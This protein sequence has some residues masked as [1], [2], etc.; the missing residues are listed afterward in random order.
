MSWNGRQCHCLRQL[1]KLKS[2]KMRSM[3]NGDWNEELYSPHLCAL[4]DSYHPTLST[5]SLCE[6]Q[7]I[8]S[9]PHRGRIG[10]NINL[11]FFPSTQ[12][13]ARAPPQSRPPRRP[14]MIASCRAPQR[15][16]ARAVLEKYRTNAIHPRRFPLL[17][18]AIHGAGAPGGPAARRYCSRGEPL[19]YDPGTSI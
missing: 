11:T 17:I 19:L 16:L 14:W 4:L 13:Q 3:R 7:K 12:R 9:S 5:A 6:D 18:P 15:A 1:E 8:L 2:R 10:G